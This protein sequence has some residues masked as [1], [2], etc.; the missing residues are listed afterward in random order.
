M[1][2]S[3]SVREFVLFLWESLYLCISAGNLC[4]L[5]RIRGPIGPFIP[6]GGPFVVVLPGCTG[7][8]WGLYTPRPPRTGLFGF[9]F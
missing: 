4:V 5:K 1:Y 7:F 9:L 2:I 3:L 6:A 8:P